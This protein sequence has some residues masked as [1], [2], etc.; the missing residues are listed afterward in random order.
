[1]K[2]CK[3]EKMEDSEVKGWRLRE[4]GVRIGCRKTLESR[5]K[6]ERERSPKKV[7]RNDEVEKNENM[8]NDSK[9]KG[10]HEFKLN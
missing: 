7:G 10:S 6:V 8:G 2:K 5:E 3:E 9:E 1:M 4:C